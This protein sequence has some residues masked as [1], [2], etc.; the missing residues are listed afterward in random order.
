M[1]SPSIARNGGLAS[2]DSGKKPGAARGADDKSVTV[3]LE[4]AVRRLEETVEQETT[5]LRSRAPIDLQAF[6][7]RKSQG[8]LELDRALRLLGANQPTAD[9]KSALK[10]LRD[11]LDL[12]REVLKTHLDAVREVAG[13]IAEAMRNAESDGTYSLSFRSKGQA[14]DQDYSA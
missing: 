6:N 14:R 13:I 7:N 1:R 10:S 12:N 4:N 9:M 11:K 5:A 3:I 2:S 8:L